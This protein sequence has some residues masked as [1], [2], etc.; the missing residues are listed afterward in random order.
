MFP[1]IT[2]SKQ[3]VHSMYNARMGGWMNECLVG[4]IS[5]PLKH[6]KIYLGLSLHQRNLLA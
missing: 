3:R 1:H 6:E 4:V 2:C 5:K